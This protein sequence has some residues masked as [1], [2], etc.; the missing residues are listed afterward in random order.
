MAERQ[1]EVGVPTDWQHPAFALPLINE[2]LGRVPFAAS[3]PLPALVRFGATIGSFARTLAEAEATG[4][5]TMNDL[6]AWHCHELLPAIRAINIRYRSAADVDT[7]PPLVFANVARAREGVEALE[8][9]R[10][11]FLNE[12]LPSS[13]LSQLAFA[14]GAQM[15]GVLD[16]L[17]ASRSTPEERTRSL[18]P[19]RDVIVRVVDEIALALSDWVGPD[20]EA[21]TAKN[22]VKRILGVSLPGNVESIAKGVADIREGESRLAMDQEPGAG[23]TCVWREELWALPRRRR[24]L[25][26]SPAT[27]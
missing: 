9:W 11:W 25:R 1:G 24:E 17:W 23:C 27:A 5:D 6:L 14:T 4:D 13:P 3:F 20:K 26:H 18:A 2:L 7:P 8:A 15:C 19:A 21:E 10:R 22:A 12:F 16:D